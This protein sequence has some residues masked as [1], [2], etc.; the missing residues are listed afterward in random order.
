MTNREYFVK[1]VNDIYDL[2]ENKEK[3][4]DAI[5]DTFSFQLKLEMKDNDIFM[6]DFWKGKCYV[7]SKDIKNGYQ[8]FAYKN[9]IVNMKAGDIT[10]T[11]TFPNDIREYIFCNWR[12]KNLMKMIEE[13]KGKSVKLGNNFTWYYFDDDNVFTG[14]GNIKS[15]KKENL[16]EFL[17]EIFEYLSGV[18]KELTEEEIEYFKNKKLL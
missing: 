10:L 13:F 7:E 5:I 4:L 11:D 15:I 14:W 12:G 2:I 17:S 16:T 6:N 9:K 18:P 1:K 8:C 3:N